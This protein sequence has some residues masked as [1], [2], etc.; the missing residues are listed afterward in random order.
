MTFKTLLSMKIYSENLSFFLA[1]LM[2]TKQWL[3]F[4][5]AEQVFVVK[6]G[7]PL[8]RLLHL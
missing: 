8:D 4:V 1:L 6:Q 7:E 5:I 3:A 2:L